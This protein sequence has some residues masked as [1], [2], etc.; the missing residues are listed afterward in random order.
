MSVIII[1]VYNHSNNI[2]SAI[3][4]FFT[5]TYEMLRQFCRQAC[6]IMGGFKFSELETSCVPNN[7]Y[8]INS[9][10]SYSFQE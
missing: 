4:P 9:S 8:Q 7:E 5:P 3:H 6:K 2:Q 10:L 1:K